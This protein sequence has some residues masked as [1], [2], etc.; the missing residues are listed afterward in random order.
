MKVYAI[1]TVVYSLKNALL[2]PHF[3]FETSACAHFLF[4]L[5]SSLSRWDI[6][7]VAPKS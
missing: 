1:A 6:S 7:F 3:P 4:W 2:L 5:V